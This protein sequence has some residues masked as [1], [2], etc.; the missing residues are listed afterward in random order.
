[1]P[2]LKMISLLEAI[3]MPFRKLTDLELADIL[4]ANLP[5]VRIKFETNLITV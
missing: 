1:M 5:D 4:S 3:D 2:A